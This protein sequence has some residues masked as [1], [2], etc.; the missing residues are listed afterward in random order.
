M[1]VT[2]SKKKLVKAR[3]DISNLTLD[4][5]HEQMITHYSNLREK[6][7]FLKKKLSD[8]ETRLSSLTDS[9]KD[10]LEKFQ[11]QNENEKII[12][13][14]KNIE[15][16]RNENIYC[17]QAMDHLFEYYNN[18]N[19][20]N[21]LDIYEEYLQILDPTYRTK[22]QKKTMIN[23]CQK[24]DV[25]RHLDSTDGL[26]I[27]SKCGLTDNII[28]EN[29]K[30]SYADG[31]AAQENNYFSYKK[32]T[33]FKEWIEQSQGKERTEIP[34]DVFKRLLEKI[35]EER[36]TNHKKLNQDKIKRYLRE[37]D[38]SKYYEHVPYILTKL[39]GQ[40]P[41]I[42]PSEVEERLERMFKVIQIAFKKC[43]PQNRRNFLSYP[44]TLHKCIQLIGDYDELLIHF[45]LL[46]SKERRKGMDDI[47]KEICTILNWEYIPS[48]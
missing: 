6:I 8:N 3:D 41:P 16:S 20:N 44:Y 45:P 1:T 12:R 25:E 33:H 40:T 17:M 2:G 22:D 9:V 42:I 7:P 36:I 31:A 29:T 24:C 28:V 15:N 10:N 23:W 38:Y 21:R 32:I 26:I 47:W 34:K 18:D 43:C 30:Q 19:K 37:L 39:N 4:A 46:K 13:E 5:K 27:C 14:I 11:I 35:K 48:L